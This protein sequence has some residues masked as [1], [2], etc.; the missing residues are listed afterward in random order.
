[1]KRVLVVDDSP[2]IAEALRWALQN[3]GH[4]VTVVTAGMRAL[5]DASNPLWAGQDVLICDLMMPHVK[6]ADIARVAQLAFPHMRRIVLPGA[7]AHGPLVE[8]AARY[9]HIVLG[10]PAPFDDILTAVGDA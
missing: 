2:T 3:E 6:G 10:K 8:E 7:D 1:M 9:A 4:E 5:L